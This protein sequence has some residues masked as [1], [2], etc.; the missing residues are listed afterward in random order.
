LG[1]SDFPD[2]LRE[3]GIQSDFMM[4]PFQQAVGVDD[5][6]RKFKMGRDSTIFYVVQR[7][8]APDS[9]DQCLKKQALEAGVRFHFEQPVADDEVDLVTAGP[10]GKP[11]KG[12]AVSEVFETDLEDQAYVVLDNSAAS[13][14]YAYFLIAGG[15]GCLASILFANFSSARRQFEMAKTKLARI[16]GIELESGRSTGGYTTYSATPQFADG[17]QLY[18]GEAASLQDPLWG[19]GVRNAMTSGFLAAQGLLKRMDYAAVATSRF[20]PLVRAGMVNRWA[21][22]TLGHTGYRGILATASHSRDL[23]KYLHRLCAPSVLNR[24]LFPVAN[25]ILDQR[26]N[27]TEPSPNFPSKQHSPELLNHP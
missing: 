1:K 2:D 11:R 19:F 24:L 9:L 16:S 7:G 8:S 13:K 6:E 23:R 14:G 22:E 15:R 18:A 4:R 27:A 20:T 3:W 12:L 17:N 10:V 26:T 21:W 25:R 5:R